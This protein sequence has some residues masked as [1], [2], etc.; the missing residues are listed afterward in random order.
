MCGVN[1]VRLMS[2]SINSIHCGV[3]AGEIKGHWPVASRTGGSRMK[4]FRVLVLLS[5]VVVIFSGCQG[6]VTEPE[7]ESAV[8]NTVEKKSINTK[9]PEIY[10][11]LYLDNTDGIR[12]TSVDDLCKIVMSMTP[13]QLDEIYKNGTISLDV[14]ELPTSILAVILSINDKLAVNSDSEVIIFVTDGSWGCLKNCIASYPVGST[15]L[16][17]CLK[18]C[19]D[20]VIP[21]QE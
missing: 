13:A 5:L 6:L 16:E 3:K 2:T 19:S 8:F 20:K 11:V 1:C 4:S 14:N 15:E 7:S 21:E 10:V 17:N 12:I 9:M 18:G